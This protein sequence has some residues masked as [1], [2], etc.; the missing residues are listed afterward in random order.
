MSIYIIATGHNFAPATCTAPATCECG[1]TEG[2]ALGHADENG[3]FKCDR[4]S[5]TMLPADGTALT[6][7]QAL[8]IAAIGG[9]S[10]TTQ[11]YYITGIVTNLYN[12]Q[13]GNFY[14]KDAEGNEICIYGLYSADGNTR[15]DAM[16]YKPV[17]GDEVTV[18]TVLG[19]YSTTKQGK[20]AWL[21]EVVAHTH[22]Y[23]ESVTAPTCTNDGYTTY[24]CSI[25]KGSY[26]GNETDALGHTTDNGE[27]ENCGQTIGG[28]ALIAQYEKIT[29]ASDFTTGTYV[30]IVNSKN[31]TV[32]TYDGSWIKGSTLKAGDTID[33]AQGDA[34]AITLEVTDSGVKIK[35]GNQYVKPKSGNNNGITSGDYTWAYEFKAD[36][37]VVFKG[38]GS[39]TTTLAYNVQS[40]GFRA[41]KNAT[42]SGNASGYP[43]FFTVYKLVN[44]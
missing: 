8:A 1:E 29:N 10:Y 17:E 4:C 35:I 33:K 20:N 26:T 24:T 34:L 6:I 23:S 31:V 37:T 5:T 42:V 13:Y 44:A 21:D 2:E 7:P 22:D 11:K 14:I 28:D 12:T 30:L 19:M 41:Y 3:D 32:S 39:D 43:S 9:T 18:Y 25:C 15:Y 16:S 36:G 40:S 27:C 38:V